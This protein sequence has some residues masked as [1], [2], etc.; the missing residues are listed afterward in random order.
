MKSF[1]KNA[2][3]FTAGVVI[4][5]VIEELT[6]YFKN[7]FDFDGLESIWFDDDTR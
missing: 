1:L 6:E 7:P 2:A 4:A 5:L 3:W